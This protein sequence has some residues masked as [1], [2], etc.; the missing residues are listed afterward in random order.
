MDDKV[1]GED[2]WMEMIKIQ[3]EGKEKLK[4]V[5]LTQAGLGRISKTQN[6]T[7]VCNGA[8]V[9]P[10]TLDTTSSPVWI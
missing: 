8:E 4:V 9:T 6:S 2:S 7:A 1:G 10:L 3:P 5:P